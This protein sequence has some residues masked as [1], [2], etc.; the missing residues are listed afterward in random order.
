MKIT[1]IPAGTRDVL[2]A[3]AAEIRYLESAIRAVFESYGYGEVI[4]PT[5]ELESA[6]EKAG[7]KRFLRSFRLFDELGEVMV[8]RP[9]MTTPIARLVATRMADR[10]PPFRL[11]YFANSFRPTTP[12]R[13][14]QSEFFQAGLELLGGD[15]ASVDAEVLAVLCGSLEACGLDD[16]SI[17]LGESSFLRALLE[18]LGVGGRASEAIFEALV[19]RDLVRLS[20]GVVALD[21]SA[22][23]RQAILDVTSL[24]G[25][26][27]VL[28]RAKDMVR[29]PEMEESLKR[30]AKTYYLV[31]RH[32]FSGRI[33]FDLGIFRN[34]DYYTGIVFEV[35]SGG[36]GFP[37]GGGGRY[38]GLLAR[39][40]RP[41]PAVG[42]AVGLDRLHIAVSGQGGVPAPAA[43][44][45]VLVG[46]FDQTLDLAGELRSAGVTV[47]VTAAGVDAA[48]AMRLAA[49]ADMRWAVIPVSEGESFLLQEVGGKAAEAEAG[50][51]AAEAEILSREEL[52]KRLAG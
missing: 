42:F 36:L 43:G 15:D 26:S 41:M 18:S 16:F 51:S 35:L 38:D 22:G 27:E 21:I 40:G 50:V 7:E 28:A 44:G 32:G 5:L 4:T 9:E 11:C 6:L 3:E 14:R 17:A 2:P 10:E 20:A 29:S 34:F 37:I 31:T 8:M 1:P 33:L 23:D 39:F 49:G 46:G 12:Q 30:L 47:A 19:A 24:R 52:V 13:G 25:G 45:V 48:E